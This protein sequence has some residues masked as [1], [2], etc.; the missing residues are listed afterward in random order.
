MTALAAQARR[1]P[2]RDR[3]VAENVDAARR[4]SLRMAR[5]CP[6]WIAREDLVA[7]GMLGLTEAAERYDGS[8]TEPFI[9][10]AE[11]RIRGA[12]LDELR[13]GDLMPRRG[14]NNAR[15]GTPTIR[16]LGD[17]YGRGPENTEDAQGPRVTVENYREE[18]GEA[19]P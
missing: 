17:K 4:I 3:L 12:V 1:S 16:T 15:Q 7:A 2:E 11:K 6:D 10:F 18:V 9:A 14:R 19:A 13:R 8:R 5:R